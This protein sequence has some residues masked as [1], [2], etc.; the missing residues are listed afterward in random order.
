M[1]QSD[2]IRI[3]SVSENDTG[4][5]NQLMNHPSVLQ[6]LNEKPT[7]KQDW[8]DAI[9]EWLCDSDEEDFIIMNGD[10]P[11]GW[12]GINGLLNE[13]RTVYLKMAVLLPD[14]QGYGFG[15]TAIHELVCGLKQRE[16]R[17]IILYTDRDNSIAQACYKKCGFKIADSLIETMSNGRIIP[18]YRMEAYL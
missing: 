7:E 1:D 4:F 3:R 15:T 16:I 17:K 18:R 12:L 13:D 5:L 2:N 11:I 10:V 9:K 8:A 14:F 6:A